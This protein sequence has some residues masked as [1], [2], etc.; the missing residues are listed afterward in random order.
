MQVL[1]KLPLS[2]SKDPNVHLD[3]NTDYYGLSLLSAHLIACACVSSPG[4]RMKHAR[5]E[6]TSQCRMR[7][8]SRLHVWA[9]EDIANSKAPSLDA[10]IQFLHK[11]PTAVAFTYIL[12]DSEHKLRGTVFL[13]G[14]KPVGH[15]ICILLSLHIVRAIYSRHGLVA[16]RRFSRSTCPL[17]ALMRCRS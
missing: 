3:E 17:R 11:H 9:G 5:R 2:L 15:L 10:A 16:A 8:S 13:K 14:K 7:M 6:N 12:P 4:C 1:D